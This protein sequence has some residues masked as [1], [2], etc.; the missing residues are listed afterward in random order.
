M[1][2]SYLLSPKAT[3]LTQFSIIYDIFIL[4]FNRFVFLLL[5]LKLINLCFENYS[6]WPLEINIFLQ[7]II[8]LYIKYKHFITYILYV[9]LHVIFNFNIKF[10]LK[11]LNT[12]LTFII[13]TINYKL[14]KINSKLYNKNTKF[15][16]KS[17]MM[18]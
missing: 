6:L 5:I 4:L 16:C 8:L 11:Q 15:F 1:Y 7:L 17:I 10:S 14:Y 12:L 13:S 9:F 18:R 2:K 3:N